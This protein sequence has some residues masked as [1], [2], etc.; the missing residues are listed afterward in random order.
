VHS[1]IN[2]FLIHVFNKVTENFKLIKCGN[3]IK[4]YETVASML[5][6]GDAEPY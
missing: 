4:S 2:L 5:K 6:T 3:R 1:C